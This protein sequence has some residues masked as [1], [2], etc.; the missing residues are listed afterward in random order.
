MDSLVKMDAK[1]IRV[2]TFLPSEIFTNSEIV[3][4]DINIHAEKII[5][6]TNKKLNSMA[7][8]SNFLLSKY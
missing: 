4:Y 2:Y 1:V 7:T 3:Y 6:T 5:D 8:S